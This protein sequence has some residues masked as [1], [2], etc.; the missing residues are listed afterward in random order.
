MLVKY[1]FV[2]DVKLRRKH[3]EKMKQVKKELKLVNIHSA[4]ILAANLAQNSW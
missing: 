2:C 3:P 4:V 1:F